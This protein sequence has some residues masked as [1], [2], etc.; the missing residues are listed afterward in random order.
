M[1]TKPLVSFSS[2][3][4]LAKG[5]IVVQLILSTKIHE[6]G[7]ICDKIDKQAGLAQEKLGLAEPA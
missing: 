4:A 1:L 3:P 5:N 6:E 7:K 2:A